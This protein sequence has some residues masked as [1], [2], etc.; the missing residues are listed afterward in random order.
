MLRS[1]AAFGGSMLRSNAAPGNSMLRSHATF[2]DSMLRSNAAFGGHGWKLRR[3]IRSE[4]TL[5][6]GCENV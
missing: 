4:A 6:G 3:S 5:V 1:N 2:G